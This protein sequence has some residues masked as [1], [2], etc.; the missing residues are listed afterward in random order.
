LGIEP[1]ITLAGCPAAAGLPKLFHFVVIGYI[2]SAQPS[3]ITDGLEL[4]IAPLVQT[5]ASRLAGRTVAGYPQLAK[6]IDLAAPGKP[7]RVFHQS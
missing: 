2:S 4:S 3:P 5:F 7:V 1:G 6:F